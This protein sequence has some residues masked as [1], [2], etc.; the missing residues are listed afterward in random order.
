[1]VHHP[2][3]PKVHYIAVIFLKKSLLLVYFLILCIQDCAKPTL[4]YVLF[5]SRKH[6]HFNECGELGIG[7]GEGGHKALTLCPPS[8]YFLKFTTFSMSLTTSFTTF[9]M[10]LMGSLTSPIHLRSK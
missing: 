5:A 2:Q 10:S 8:L 4:N 3:G 9:T 6:V 1:M 7:K